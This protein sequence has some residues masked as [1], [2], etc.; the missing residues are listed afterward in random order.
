MNIVQLG[1]SIK[2]FKGLQRSKSY[3][4]TCPSQSLPRVL[5]QYWIMHKSRMQKWVFCVSAVLG[6]CIY[7][8]THICRPAQGSSEKMQ[9]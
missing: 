7:S 2:S 3:N 5:F 4:V 9:G 6:P 8:K 1:D